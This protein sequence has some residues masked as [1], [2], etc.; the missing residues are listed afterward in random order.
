MLR[1]RVITAVVLLALLAAVL[2][3]GSELAFQ[4]TLAAF[5]GAA[6]WESLRLLGVKLA[7]PLAVACAAGLLLL[8]G[9][10]PGNDW[11]LLAG[12]CVVVWVLRFAPALK[13]GLPPVEGMRGRLFALVYLFALL[14]CFLAI[15][16]LYRRSGIYLV[17]VM[18]LVWVA[19]IGAY[20]AGR[21]F[22]R[23]KL[24]PSISPGK[25]WEGAIG[26][27]IAV[28]LLAA[29]S[30]RDPLF[31]DTFAVQVQSQGGWIQWLVL[32]TLVVAAS[33][34]GDLFESLMKRRAGMKDSSSLL[35]GHGGVLDRIDALIPVM[36][37][38]LL[39][40][41]RLH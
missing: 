4:L 7:L 8:L 9:F 29:A 31:A 20:F 33:V 25:S 27:W 1:E 40:G 36:P 11:S 6:C 18:A 39:I 13:L 35:P 23:R 3:S 12:L 17:S 24:A 38:A 34:V 2:G 19:D 21:A 15:E 16:A 41:A 32:M 10:M 14:G 37:L 5:F 26:G 28:V 22:G 30:T